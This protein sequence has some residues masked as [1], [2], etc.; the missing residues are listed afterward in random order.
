MVGG[1]WGA[2]G[3]RKERAVV[4]LERRR[5][6]GAYFEVVDGEGH[7][8]AVPRPGAGAGLRSTGAY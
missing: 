1:E 4:P 3:D 2:L 5:G 8:V 7:R 6:A